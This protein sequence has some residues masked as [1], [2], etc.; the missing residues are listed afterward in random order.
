VTT[1]S[2]KHLTTLYD[3]YDILFCDVWGVLH[4][5]V[6]VFPAA[7]QALIEA[8]KA[9]KLV[10]LLTNS[11][12]TCEDVIAQ[13]DSMGAKAQCYDGVVTSGDATRTL[14]REAPKRLFLIGPNYDIALFD[15]LDKELVEEFE[16]DGIIVTG[17]NDDSYETPE[18]YRDVL[19][20]LRGRNLPLICANPDIEVEHGD[21]RRW[22]AGSLARDYANLG[23]RVFVAGKPH[24]PIYAL[25]Q[26]KAQEILGQAPDKNRIL[27]IGDGIL[28]DVKGAH[29]N[30][31]D[32]LY[33]ARGIHAQHYVTDAQVDQ[34][35]MI[36]F[37]KAHNLT[38][39]Y[40]M[41][42]LA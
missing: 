16:A 11:P 1:Q 21:K 29:M 40:M 24:E 17:L 27:A 6:S 32:I 35:K 39:T 2:I 36:S 28:T 41:M 31:L 22:C 19:E 10:I 5:G 4:N 42:G 30:N 25:A 34:Q 12:R 15:G 37:F 13:L 33:I 20:R 9:G 8:R 14:L 3:R 38:P 18:D 26:Q 7:E 23:G